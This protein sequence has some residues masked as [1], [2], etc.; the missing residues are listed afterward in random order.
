VLDVGVREEGSLEYRIMSYKRRKWLS[1]RGFGPPKG[2]APR[3]KVLVVEDNQDARVLMEAIL[4]TLGLEVI[5][6]AD[7]EEG[8]ERTLEESP[9]LIITD[10]SMPRVTGLQLIRRLRG[11]PG[12][13]KI[14]ILAVTAYGIDKAI[15]AIKAGANRALTRPIENHLLRAFVFD[16]LNSHK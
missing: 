8:F 16:L 6:A 4:E 13:K 3:K 15:E 7:G 2:N 5:D 12:F 14:P 1:G 10:I 11:L 9:D